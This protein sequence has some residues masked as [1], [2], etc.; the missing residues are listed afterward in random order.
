[1][2]L[3]QEYISKEIATKRK[4]V[5]LYYIFQPTTGVERFYTSGDT[6]IEFEGHTYTPATLKRSLIKYDSQLEITTCTI[7]AGYLEE[8]LLEFIAINPIDTYWI[9]IM[10][11]FRD[12]YPLEANVIFLGQIKSVSFQGIQAEIEC[13]GFEHFFKMP[14]PKER[15]QTTCNWQVFDDK[16]RVNKDDYKVTTI[17]TLDQTKTILTSSDFGSKPN[18][19]F[20]GGLVEFPLGKEKRTIVAHNGNS[21]TISYRMIELE[22][23]DT[24]DAYPGCDGRPETCRDKFDNIL[25]FF[26]FPY[27]PIE[28]PVLRI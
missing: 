16:C 7:Q 10:K 17:V 19:Y 13:V 21:I 6:P 26:G 23:G 8:T 24:I 25:N 11:L 14:I 22:T 3:S 4:P 1:M 28:N 15:Y 9:K 27:I 5:E 18:G 20:I 2:T 12:Q